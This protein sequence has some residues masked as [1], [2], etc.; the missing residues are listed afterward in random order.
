[1]D[2][3]NDRNSRDLADTER[4]QEEMG[5]IQERTVQKKDLNEPDN[6]DDVVS[7]PESDM[8]ECEVK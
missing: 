1:M 2:T 5:R 7:Y 3:I 8:L 6:Y 4:D